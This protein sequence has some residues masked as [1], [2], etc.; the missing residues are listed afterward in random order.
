MLATMAASTVAAKG[1]EYTYADIGYEYTDIDDSKEGKNLSLGVV[2]GSFSTFEHVALR[3]V[4]KRGRLN[5]FPGQFGESD[6]DFTEFQ[7]GAWGH[8]GLIK[9]KLDVFAGANWFY[10]SRNSQ[11]SGV[12]DNSDS[13][14][15]VDA[16]IRYAAFKRVE[17]EAGG[18]YRTG[19][20]DDGA[21]FLGP[22]ISLTKHLWLNL[23]STQLGDNDNYYA[24][25]RW[26]F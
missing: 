24:G 2:D 17:F 9:N 4:F 14:A 25:L 16:G 22:R 1:F 12:S 8:Y 3:A 26:D 10:N 7:F 6:P 11:T 13:G 23:K 20:L 19:N 5:D 15:I 21:V 18:I